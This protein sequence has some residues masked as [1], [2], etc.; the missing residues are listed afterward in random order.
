[1]NYLTTHR[2]IP[3][4]SKIVV[5]IFFN[6]SSQR[7]K[8]GKDGLRGTPAFHTF[9]IQ[10]SETHPLFDFL[11]CGRGRERADS[12]I[13]QNFELFIDNPYCRAMFLAV[14]YD[15]GFVRMLEPYQYSEDAVSKIVLIKAGQVAPAFTSV[16]LFK[17]TEFKSVFQELCSLK[18]GPIGNPMCTTDDLKPTSVQLGETLCTGDD[19]EVDDLPI[20]DVPYNQWKHATPH[21]HP[22]TTLSIFCETTL[23]TPWLI[24][25]GILPF[26]LRGSNDS[27]N[28]SV[29]A[30]GKR[31]TKWR[32]QALEMAIAQKKQAALQPGTSSTLQEILRLTARSLEGDLA[33]LKREVEQRTKKQLAGD[34]NAQARARGSK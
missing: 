14:C 26:Q 29:A 30:M 24:A 17:F 4:H 21:V 27:T 31:R 12:K 20:E 9:M 5:R 2:E 18:I 32:I 33:R 13:K 10:F 6:A 1:M 19:G 28:A 11:D 34:T 15:G 7:G 25:L 8:L 22:A 23:P 3:L 16:P